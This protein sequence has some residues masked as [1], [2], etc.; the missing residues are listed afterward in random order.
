MSYGDLFHYPREGD[1]FVSSPVQL[2][3]IVANDPPP[4]SSSPHTFDLS[5]DDPIFSLFPPPRASPELL[6]CCRDSPL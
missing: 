3:D 2:G 5:L 1:I 4:F 6:L